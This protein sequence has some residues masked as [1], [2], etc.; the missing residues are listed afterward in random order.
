MKTIE[1]SQGQHA[2]VDDEDYEKVT[3][4]KWCVQKRH[5]GTFYVVRTIKFRLS[6]LILDSQLKPNEYIE[7]IN[8]DRLD[9]RKCNLKVTTH[10]HDMHKAIQ[11]NDTSSRYKGVH[12]SKKDKR[13]HARIT[14]ESDRIWLGSFLSEEEASNAVSEAEE[15][16]LGCQ[17]RDDQNDE[18]YIVE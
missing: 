8:G 1:L 13:W 9:N 3:Q 6:N 17:T 14:V 10:S 15:K 5:D 4:N 7:H 16:Y 12:W 11:K 18:Y 2:I